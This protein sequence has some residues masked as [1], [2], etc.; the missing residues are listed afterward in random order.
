MSWGPSKAPFRA[1]FAACLLASASA[2]LADILVVRSTGP[3]AKSF[4]PGK[5]IAEGSKVVLRANDSI[6]LLDG[7]GTRT[8]RGPGTFVAGA[9]AG[10]VA[11]AAPVTQRRARIGAVRS[12][13]GGELRPPSIWH[14]DV[15][16]ASTYCVADVNKVTLWRSDSTGPTTLSIVRAAGGQSTKVNWE[17]GS[18]TVAWPSSLPIT[19]N[20]EFRLST[21]GAS[22][23]T[24]IRFRILREPERGLENMASFLLTNQCSA[25]LDMFIE[26]VRL[27]DE[28]PPAG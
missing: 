24:S 8:L 12:V 21:A 5:R 13:G 17:A 3:S 26:M 16:K 22:A 19:D 14:V 7:R 25:Q 9:A 27:P 23:P 18:T 28:A 2:A 15:S 11:G 20:S 4:P 6:D 10:R 1:L